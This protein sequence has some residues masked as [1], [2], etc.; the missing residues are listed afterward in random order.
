MN[1][2]FGRTSGNWYSISVAKIPLLLHVATC[3]HMFYPLFYL[4]VCSPPQRKV[5]VAACSAGATV[6]ATRWGNRW[7]PKE[8]E[9]KKRWKNIHPRDRR[10]SSYYVL[11][12]YI[13]LYSLYCQKLCLIHFSIAKFPWSRR[14]TLVLVFLPIGV[15]RHHIHTDILVKE[16][17]LKKQQVENYRRFKL[18]RLRS[19]PIC[20]IS[21]SCDPCVI[22]S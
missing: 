3:M 7:A 18:Q 4:L 5:S 15:Q 17:P 8:R 10:V 14:N 9:N 13:I 22:T 11:L 1:T 21:F 16:T 2:R 12:Q 6:S 19:V 20:N